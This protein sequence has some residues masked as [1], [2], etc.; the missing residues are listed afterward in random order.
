[1]SRRRGLTLV[2]AVVSI[3]ACPWVGPANAA[4]PT[5]E[6]IEVDE[7][8]ADEFL[9]EECG[10]DVTTHIVGRVRLREFDRTKGTVAV[11]NVNFTLTATAGD[12]TA[13]FRDVGADHARITPDGQMIL[14]ITGQVPFDFKG[15]LK[16]DPETD[17]VF[18]EPSAAYDT[19][20]VCARLTA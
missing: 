16:I 2:V 14:S 9:T 12:N 4:K 5:V 19:T 7:T 3:V 18:H 6:V 1:M 17:E 8:I 15:V 20:R 13:R 11:N 10:V